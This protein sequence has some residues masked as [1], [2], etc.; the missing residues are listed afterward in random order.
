MKLAQRIRFNSWV[1]AITILCM[2]VVT[3]HQLYRLS[4]L[5]THESLLMDT[6]RG[7]LELNT[8]AAEYLDDCSERA[9]RQWLRR[10]RH[11]TPLIDALSRTQLTGGFYNASLKT[12]HA[13]LLELFGRLCSVDREA[14]GQPA[15]VNRDPLEQLAAGQMVA[16]VQR[17]AFRFYRLHL[18]TQQEIRNTF[19]G[20]VALLAISFLLISLLVVFDFRVIRQRILAPV[21]A[22]VSAVRKVGGGDLEIRI[23]SSARDELGDLARTFDQ[24]AHDLKQITVS[25]DAFSREADEHQKAAESLQHLLGRYRLIMEGAGVGIWDWDVRKRRVNYSTEWKDM[26]GYDADEV[27]DSEDEWASG[28]HPDDRGRVMSAVQAH[29]DGDSPV[30]DEEYRVRHKGKGWIWVWDRGIALRDTAGR[31]VRMAGSEVDITERKL[32]E[33]S[34][35]ESERALRSVV[36]GLPANIVLLDE[37]SNILLVNQGWRRFWEQNDGDPSYCWEGTNYITACKPAFGEP[38]DDAVAMLEGLKSVLAGERS[39]FNMEYPCHSPTKE[40][41]FRAQ[42]VLFVG[43][44]P[45]RAIIAHQDITEYRRQEA[46]A[47]ELRRRLVQAQKMESVGQLS[48]G[49]AHDFNNLLAIMLGHLELLEADLGEQ[50]GQRRRVQQVRQAA[51]RAAQLTRQLLGFARQKPAQSETCR[52][53]GLL[54]EMGELIRRS[55]TPAVQVQCSSD[56]GLWPVELDPG[57]FQ[58]ALLNLVNNAR[59]AMPGGG[60][61]ILETTNTELD[62]A[63]CRSHPGASP[64]EYVKVS[65]NDTGTGMESERLEHIFEPFYTTKAVGRGTGLGLAMV[66]GFTKRSGGYVTVCSEPGIGT[67]VHLYLP[68]F[69][70]SPKAGEAMHEEMAAEVAAGAGTVLVVDDESQLR[71]LAVETL[72]TRGYRV[73]SAGS[74][75]EA[76]AVL[77]REP[78]IDLLFSDVV[79]PGAVDGYELAERALAERP[80]LKVL[81]T[82]GYSQ[83]VLGRDRRGMAPLLVKPYRQRELA[84]RVGEL[85]SQRVAGSA[86]R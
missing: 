52:L 16:G 46:E 43:E 14:D 21:A 64:G 22:L 9:R 37:H 23:R 44:G 73:L 63:Y 84:R 7:L 40:R 80:A 54:E 5:D 28:I 2:F 3:A 1:L 85:L 56:E 77:A 25:R 41:W 72:K 75:K 29:F 78:G 32:S 33:A 86:G 18:L 12:E 4:D 62:D 47:E 79:M 68:R 74:G 8:V 36:N 65:V 67:T 48:G 19:F 70:G 57:D 38:D 59:D 42:A 83:K 15:A 20:L 10:H 27:G 24:M 31:V 82:S 76:L 55:V 71:E 49:I 35:M 58:D 51:E 81:L 53:N 11:L 60:R 17:L 30:F 61:L 26:R 13:R 39:T 69:T 45:K 6:N 34:L 50:A 66:Y